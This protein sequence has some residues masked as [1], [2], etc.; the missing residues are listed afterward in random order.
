MAHIL[1][2]TGAT[3]AG[4]SVTLRYVEQRRGPE[5]D[6][7][8]IQKYTTRARR[9][10][11][12]EKESKPVKMMP[13]ECDLVY[14]QY[15]VRYGLSLQSLHS[16][17]AAGRTP[18]LVVNDIRVLDEIREV[19]GPLMRSIYVFRE[20]PSIDRIRA[21]SQDRGGVSDEEI[22]RRFRKAQSIFRIFIENI[23]AFDYVV[24]NVR[25]F[26]D[27]HVQIDTI[28]SRLVATTKRTLRSL[29]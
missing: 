29:S 18:I 2:L 22:T 7:V 5:F 15:G 12:D 19:F 6:P 16:N 9:T 17:V 24:M 8:V 20:I 25:G 3:G 13:P 4:K 1:T 10:A 14:E 27:L 28:I 26:E 21:L 11:E 23:E